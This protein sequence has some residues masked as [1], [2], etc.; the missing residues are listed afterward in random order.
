M[1]PP[2][3]GSPWKMG[4]LRLELGWERALCHAGFRGSSA[5]RTWR[6]WGLRAKRM[7]HTTQCPGHDHLQEEVESHPPLLRSHFSPSALISGPSHPFFI[8]PTAP[9]IYPSN[10]L[11][12]LSWARED[13]K[14]TPAPDLRKL[15]I[16]APWIIY[17]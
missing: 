2:G 7:P 13:G 6:G 5:S 1:L 11:S 9:S 15:P 16:S 8:H 12:V 17:H 10:H 3:L 14:D 4:H